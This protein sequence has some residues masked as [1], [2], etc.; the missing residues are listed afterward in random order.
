M[1]RKE[2]RGNL[3]GGLFKSKAKSEESIENQNSK[4]N[5][6]NSITQQNAN[7]TKYKIFNNNN[8]NNNYIPNANTNA[9][10]DEQSFKYPALFN[11]DSNHPP[12]PPTPNPN[13]LTPTPTPPSHP[14][15]PPSHHYQ[16]DDVNGLTNGMKRLSAGTPQSPL[17]PLQ[18]QS[19]ENGI[20]QQHQQNH[21]QQEQH[22]QQQQQQQQLQLICP[23]PSSF[24]KSKFTGKASTDSMEITTEPPHTLSLSVVKGS[25]GSSKKVK[26]KEP[27]YNSLPDQ[28]RT[29][30]PADTLLT[31]R[32]DPL[33]SHPLI[34]QYLPLA[35]I[36]DP[37]AQMQLAKLH[38]DDP[39]LYNPELAR[40]WYE[41]LV[42]TQEYP[43]AFTM[44][45]VL[46]YEGVFHTG[47]DGVRGVCEPRRFMWTDKCVVIQPKRDKHHQPFPHS[48][49]LSKEEWALAADYFLRAA[50]LGSTDGMVQIGRFY[51]RTPILIF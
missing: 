39:I 8:N 10:S 34:S 3:F 29:S 35:D 31:S 30:T 50:V 7:N 6:H 26:G 44:L 15:P 11:S 1:E 2:K 9:T 49:A 27:A 40:S 13:P 14:A 21:H 51:V 47:K 24:L 17:P 42:K 18:R 41:H 4:N 28:P 20:P 38:L 19:H 33:A 16:S 23:L 36:G 32:P 45:G 46:I 37:D 25:S 43:P 22:Q 5:S 12:L 48:T